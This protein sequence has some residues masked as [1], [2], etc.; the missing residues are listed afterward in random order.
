MTRSPPLSAV[1]AVCFD[2]GEV[3][4][5]ETTVW[6]AW[7]D[8]L[9]VPRHTF[10]AVF[11]AVIAEGRDHR[12]VFERLRP[13]FD[14]AVERRRRID[15]GHAD[16]FEDSDVYPDVRSCLTKLRSLGLLVALAGNQA[17]SAGR[18]LREMSLPVDLIATSDDW[19]VAKP[20]PE[21]FDKLITFS[22]FP[23][24]Q[25]LYVGDR[26]DN[27]IGPAQE[28]GML[29]AL[30]RR[31]PWAHIQPVGSGASSADYRIDSL[32]ELPPLFAS[33]RR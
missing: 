21:F 24:D 2:V 28:S 13:G 29:A 19:G 25:I 9:G 7:A 15:A 32:D 11:G 6:A 16:R 30:I 26:V 5:D 27:D 8:W 14:L 22:G 1:R 18:R 4:V 17:A 33:A 23:A 20:S 12:E 31:G 10:S 3:I